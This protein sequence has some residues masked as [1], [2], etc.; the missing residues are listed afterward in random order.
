MKGNQAKSYKIKPEKYPVGLNSKEKLIY[1]T[2][3]DSVESD[4]R[5][6]GKRSK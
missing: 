5:K 2:F 6:I 1:D 3:Y 4:L